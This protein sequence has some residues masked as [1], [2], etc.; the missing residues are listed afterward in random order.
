METTRVNLILAN[1]V[2]AIKLVIRPAA[3]SGWNH[4]LRNPVGQSSNSMSYTH[5]GGTELP[6]QGQ[7]IRTYHDEN[8]I[9]LPKNTSGQPGWNLFRS[10]AKGEVS[11]SERKYDDF[12]KNAYKAL[13]MFTMV[14][15]FL[16]TLAATIVSKGATFLMV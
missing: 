15:V 13:K 6:V 16:V 9:S 3:N 11:V 10:T 14:I 7:P 8:G 5:S 2:R 12:L 1:T 4:S